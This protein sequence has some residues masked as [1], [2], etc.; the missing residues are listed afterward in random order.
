MRR[1]LVVDDDMRTRLAVS[2]WLAPSPVATRSLRKPSRPATL[3]AV[4]DEYLSEAEQR[5]KS[6]ATSA[7][8]DPDS[9]A[10]IATE[11]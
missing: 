4:T 7:K 8:P 3:L 1:I 5:R 10:T 2:V 6:P 9:P 11:E